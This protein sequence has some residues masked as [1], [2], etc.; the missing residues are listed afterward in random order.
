M[1]YDIKS[2][3]RMYTLPDVWWDVR[4]KHNNTTLY[5][6]TLTVL[7]INILLLFSKS[8]NYKLVIF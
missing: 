6:C 3:A 4:L 2:I 7:N 8:F 1:C 5:K